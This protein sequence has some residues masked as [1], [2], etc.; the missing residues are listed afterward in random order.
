M[1]TSR[2][3]LLQVGLLMT[4]LDYLVKELKGNLAVDEVVDGH[5]M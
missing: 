5:A 4:C 2:H 3:S 1:P